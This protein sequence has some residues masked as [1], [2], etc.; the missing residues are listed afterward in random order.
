MRGGPCSSLVNFIA[1]GA[2]IISKS[3]LCGAM[4]PRF[5]ECGIS[6]EATLLGLMDGRIGKYGRLSRMD[7][8]I[9]QVNRGKTDSTRDGDRAEGWLGWMDEDRET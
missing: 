4:S 2:I 5:S 8:W 9:D 7:G 3:K 6:E 1:E